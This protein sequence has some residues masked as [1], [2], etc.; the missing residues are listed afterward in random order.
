MA[1]L[2]SS[3]PS[4][5]TDP[6]PGARKTYCIVIPDRRHEPQAQQGNCMP[7]YVLASTATT[8]VG[9]EAGREDWNAS[10]GQVEFD[11]FTVDSS[12]VSRTS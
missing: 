11:E 8:L 6:V 7:G 9:C 10:A 2:A 5:S 12:R 1:G 3:L 4:L